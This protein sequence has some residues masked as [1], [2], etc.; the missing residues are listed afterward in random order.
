MGNAGM[1]LTMLSGTIFRRRGRALMAVIAAAIG[2]ATLFCLA[3]VCLEVPRQMNEEMRSYGANL[4]V[5]PIERPD[6][7]RTDIAAPMVAHTTEMVEAKGPTKFATYRYESVRINS[8]SYLMAGISAG[9]VRELNHHWNVEGSWPKQGQVMVGRDV[10]EA[11]GLKVGGPV[12][13][14]YLEADDGSNRQAGQWTKDKVLGK[15]SY[16]VAGIVETGGS[17]DQIVYASLPDLEA[18]THLKRGTDVIEYSSSAMG[19]NLAAIATAINEMTSMGVKAQTVTK[20]SSA[21]NR[22]ITMLQTLFWQVSLVV[23]VL[24][25]V[26]VG[27]TMA[28][29]VS[30]RRSEIALRK[31]LGAS[32]SGLAFEFYV[33]SACYGLLGGVLGVGIGYAFARLLCSSVFGRALGL[34]WPLALAAVALSII[35]ALLGSIEPVW[36]ASHIDPALVLSQE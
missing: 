26:G 22:I 17:E 5:A 29:I 33:E 27:T 19:S 1:F 30:Q 10:A 8:A 13:V 12:E 31:A 25:L 32:S 16:R 14:R 6:Q 3:A 34:S 4:V 7:A 11:M 15:A 36:R 23:L 18:L 35:M 20:I 21:D 9:Q 24:T 2:A 28:S